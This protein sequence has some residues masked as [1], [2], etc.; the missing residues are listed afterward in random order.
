MRNF[1]EGDIVTIRLEKL[2]DFKYVPG[3][4]DRVT[5]PTGKVSSTWRLDNTGAGVITIRL[6]ACPEIANLQFDVDDVELL[7]PVEL[8][9]RLK[10]VEEALG[11]NQS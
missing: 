2:S 3:F 9:L 11:L 8:D 6:D 4:P 5:N 1:K 7:V 10:A